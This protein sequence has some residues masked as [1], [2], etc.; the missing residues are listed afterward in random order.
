MSYHHTYINIVSTSK[1]FGQIYQTVTSVDQ[2]YK[3]IIASVRHPQCTAQTKNVPISALNHY[4]DVI[5][6]AMASQITGLAIVYSI[7]YSGTDQRKHQSSA[8]L[9]FVRGIHRDRWIPRTKGQLRAKCF[10]LMTSSWTMH[11]GTCPAITEGTTG[12][13]YNSLFHS[14]S[15]FRI[16]MVQ[17]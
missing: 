12:C 6:G 14:N 15:V 8:S 7:L 3:P 5:M 11:C 2:S 16:R 13:Q 17:T 9:A 1:Q 4:D 10:H